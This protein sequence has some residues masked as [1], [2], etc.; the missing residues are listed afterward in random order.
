M[1][2]VADSAHSKWH[3]NFVRDYGPFLGL[4]CYLPIRPSEAI[5]PHGLFLFVIRPV[6]QVGASF[7]PFSLLHTLNF[8]CNLP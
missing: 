1:C 3:C 2:R 8:L 6:F 7:S 5:E 4:T